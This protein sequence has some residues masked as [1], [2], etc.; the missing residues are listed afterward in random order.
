MVIDLLDHNPTEAMLNSL[1]QSTIDDLNAVDK[2]RDI[3]TETPDID[4][5]DWV[6]DARVAR[7]MKMLLSGMRLRVVPVQGLSRPPSPDIKILPQKRKATKSPPVES[8]SS[9]SSSSSSAGDSGDLGDLGD[10]GDSGDSVV[11]GDSG[12]GQPDE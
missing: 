6:S 10:S 3:L 11:S 2:I 5:D 12:E 1:D 7:R 9:S 8:S 4:E